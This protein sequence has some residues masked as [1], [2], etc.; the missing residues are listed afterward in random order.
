MKRISLFVL[1]RCI[2]KDSCE[3]ND[4]TVRTINL[5]VE[6]F[7]EASNSKCLDKEMV[8]CHAANV[9]NRPANDPDPKE[10]E[11][12]D[13]CEIFFAGAGTNFGSDNITQDQKDEFLTYE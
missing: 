12:T 2:F 5:E 6:I 8:C 11:S 10:D 13:Q 4:F 3:T 1:F 7:D 9:K